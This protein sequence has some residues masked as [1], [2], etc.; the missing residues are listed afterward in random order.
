MI[1][2]TMWTL[3]VVILTALSPMAVSAESIIT[4]DGVIA[5]T[6][7]LAPLGSPLTY[8]RGGDGLIGFA[9]TFPTM[10][11]IPANRAIAANSYDHTWLQFDPEI[12]WSSA[13]PLRQVFAIPGV[14]H[15]PVPQEN[16]EFILWGANAPNGVWEEGRIFAIYRDGFDTA[17]TVAGHS[18]DYTSL[19]EFSQAY[20][21]FRATS[22][23]HLVPTYG[24]VGEGE[25]DA[26][27]AAAVAVPEPG[28]MFLMA[29]GL[30]MIGRRSLRRTK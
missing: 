12:V 13:T 25:I 24:S 10:A 29:T 27:A 17:N 23:D 18:D 4:T 20:S 2:N 6:E 21:F 26:L 9:S 15:D 30:A 7:S 5:V 14:D 19:W 1:R 28:T 3:V 8:V 16:L 22:G 11:D